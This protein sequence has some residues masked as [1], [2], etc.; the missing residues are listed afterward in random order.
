[1]RNNEVS[2]KAAISSLMETMRRQN[3]EGD[4]LATQTT[5]MI[6][7]Y[8]G[9]AAI[10]DQAVVKETYFGILKFRFCKI[11]NIK[12]PRVYLDYE[13]SWGGVAFYKKSGKNCRSPHGQASLVVPTKEISDF[14]YAY[15]NGMKVGTNYLSGHAQPFKGD[16][17]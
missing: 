15:P 3:A 9:A 6:S 11:E 12:G 8:Y 4:P 7:A 13:P 10:G 5:E 16:A 14:G 17:T 2:V 1:M